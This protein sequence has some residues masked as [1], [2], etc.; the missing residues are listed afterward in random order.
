MLTVYLDSQDYSRLSN[1]RALRQDPALQAVLDGFKFWQKSSKVRFV[2]SD[3][4]VG[5]M[6]PLDAFSVS[7]AVERMRLLRD[8]CGDNALVPWSA[9]A[10]KEVRCLHSR[11]CPNKSEFFSQKFWTPELGHIFPIS[12]DAP[13][14][15]QIIEEGLR[16]KGYDRSARRR[17]MPGLLRKAFQNRVMEMKAKLSSGIIHLSP[18]GEIAALQWAAGE[19]D[20]K[21]ANERVILSFQDAEWLASTAKYDMKLISI[22]QKGIREPA[23]TAAT[24]MLNFI[25]NIAA[26]RAGS[27][28]DSKKKS[29]LDRVSW[30][31]LRRQIIASNIEGVAEYCGLEVDNDLSVDIIRKF[32]PGQ[33]VMHSA[34]HSSV[35]DSIFGNRKSEPDSN[36]YTDAMHASYA[37]YVDIF[38][39][40]KFMSP[41]IRSQL[42]ENGTVV[43][44]LLADV[45]KAIEDKL[46]TFEGA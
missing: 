18:E 33:Y 34:L 23:R 22:F 35:G 40:D 19:I 14:L 2:F 11:N 41:H 12:P 8:L 6:L 5:E 30:E 45:N 1:L 24:A 43:V 10:T 17:V 7:D 15:D 26:N 32:C 16:A 27:N 44:R 29:A 38:R 3:V 20:V 9:L 4:V 13:A 31:S 42:I 39:A 25:N 28:V 37:P 21:Q 36:Q 46:K